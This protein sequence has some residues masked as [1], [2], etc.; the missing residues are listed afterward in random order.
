MPRHDAPHAAFG[1]DRDGFEQIV[2]FDGDGRRIIKHADLPGAPRLSQ[3]A[4]REDVPTLSTGDSVRH[5]TLGEGVVIQIE[6]GG[7]VTV[8]FADGEERRLMLD[9]APLERIA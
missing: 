7:V 9:Y 2:A 6:S 1:A 5:S 3:V 4:P 8:R